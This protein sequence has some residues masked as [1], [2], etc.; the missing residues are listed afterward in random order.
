MTDHPL[1]YI[2]CGVAI[3]CLI[4]TGCCC[5]ARHCKEEKKESPVAMESSVP[6]PQIPG[7]YYFDGDKLEKW[8]IGTF[9]FTAT[10]LR[11][12]ELPALDADEPLKGQHP[13]Y[14]MPEGDD[15]RAFY[16]DGELMMPLR[17]YRVERNKDG[18]LRLVPE[19]PANPN[20]RPRTIP[21][22]K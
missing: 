3:S 22:K 17:S 18:S 10:G 1:R 9:S 7:L 8:G 19:P 13:L 11:D 5:P 21:L 12:F 16:F 4:T 6:A 15:S 14:V 20:A 2:L